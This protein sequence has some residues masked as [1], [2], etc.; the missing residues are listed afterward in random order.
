MRG[1][2]VVVCPVPVVLELLAVLLSELLEELALVLAEPEEVELVLVDP[3]PL[4]PEEGVE[5]AVEELGLGVAS[6]MTWTRLE[7]PHSSK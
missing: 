7:V 2:L 6:M 5:L 1:R 4:V 3:E